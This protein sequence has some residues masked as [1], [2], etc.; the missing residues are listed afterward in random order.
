M[1]WTSYKQLIGAIEMLS[2]KILKLETSR[3]L[4]GTDDGIQKN[5]TVVRVTM[6]RKCFTASYYIV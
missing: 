4:F 1:F 6:L 3:V 2:G 5:E